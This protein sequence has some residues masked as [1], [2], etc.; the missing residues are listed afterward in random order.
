MHYAALSFLIGSASVAPAEL[1]TPADLPRLHGRTLTVRV[2][3]D[4]CTWPWSVDDVFIS[5]VRARPQM[6]WTVFGPPLEQE[7]ILTGMVQ[8]IHHP[9]RIIGGQAFVGFTEVRLWVSGP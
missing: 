1:Y 8:V 6:H 9:A 2:S 7:T 3:P 5:G 4:P